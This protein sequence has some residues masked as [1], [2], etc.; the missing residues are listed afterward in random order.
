MSGDSEVTTIPRMTRVYKDTKANL[1][2]LPGLKTEDLG[3]G[4]DTGILYRWS[5]INWEAVSSMLAYGSY[6]GNNSANRAIPHGLS[7]IPKLVFIQQSTTH[8]SFVQIM[9]NFNLEYEGGATHANYGTTVPDS[10]NF[11]VG[12]AA[13]YGQS[14]NANA[15]AYTWVAI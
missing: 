13:N 12:N 10:T 6:T 11:Y 2:L 15:V 14:A 4:T 8:D 7:R 5:G 3:Y 9:I 1:D